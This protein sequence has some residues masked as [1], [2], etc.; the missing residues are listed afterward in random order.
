MTFIDLRP[1]QLVLPR[2]NS[3]EWSNGNKRT[4]PKGTSVSKLGSAN[5][6]HKAPKVREFMRNVEFESWQCADRA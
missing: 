3:L 6:R 2:Y 4:Q 1:E 5:L